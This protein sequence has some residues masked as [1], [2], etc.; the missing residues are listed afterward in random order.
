MQVSEDVQAVSRHPDALHGSR[1]LVP[2]LH[3]TNHVLHYQKG[4]S[5]FFGVRLRLESF[6]N[7][8]SD[9][10]SSSCI[11]DLRRLLDC[12]RPAL[13]G[14]SE[15]QTECLWLV[16]VRPNMQSSLALPVLTGKQFRLRCRCSALEE[17][18]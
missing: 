16:G 4:S 7:Q 17:A 1:L 2:V 5:G 15:Q 11:L 10:P 8:T 9:R 12:I 13:P 18:K 6:S 3:S 14:G